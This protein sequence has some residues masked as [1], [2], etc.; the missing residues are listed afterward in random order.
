MKVAAGMEVEL[1]QIYLPKHHSYHPKMHHNKQTI[2]NLLG[3]NEG[4]R[5][6]SP[7]YRRVV[8]GGRGDQGSGYH[9]GACRL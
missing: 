2:P 7:S 5:S 6:L 9:E 3:Q 8:S 1:R 4:T